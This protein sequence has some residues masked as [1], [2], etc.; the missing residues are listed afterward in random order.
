[1][2]I[3]IRYKMADFL[4]MVLQED[5]ARCYAKSQAETSTHELQLL[6]H[7]CSSEN[8]QDAR[9]IVAALTGSYIMSNTGSD[10]ISEK[11]CRLVQDP[12]FNLETLPKWKYIGHDAHIQ[13]P[14]LDRVF[15][16]IVVY[17]YQFA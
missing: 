11:M 10:Q 4:L 12:E 15:T 2:H 17:N 5:S 16:P 3:H 9:D 14:R 13:T 7:I 8:R 1:M 6:S